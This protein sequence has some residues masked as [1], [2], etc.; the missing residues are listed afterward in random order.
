MTIDILFSMGTNTI[1]ATGDMDVAK[2]LAFPALFLETYDGTGDFG[3][4][5]W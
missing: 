2:R 4:V 1:L 5:L 3:L